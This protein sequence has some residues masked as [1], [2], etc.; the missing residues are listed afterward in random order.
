[1]GHPCCDVIDNSTDFENKLNRVIS[2]VCKRLKKVQGADIDIKRGGLEAN[3]R[4]R[5]FLVKEIK[6]GYHFQVTAKTVF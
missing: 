4:K 3:S 2:V 5:K 6:V 1:M